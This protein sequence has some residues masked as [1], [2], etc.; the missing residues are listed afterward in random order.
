MT[1]EEL[2]HRINPS[3]SPD[4]RDEEWVHL[5]PTE[6]TDL[7]R[8]LQEAQERVAA[9]TAADKAYVDASL[10]RMSRHTKAAMRA[11]ETA[12]EVKFQA[13]V[14]LH[15]LIDPAYAQPAGEPK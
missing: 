11:E 14:A 3:G 10:H 15:E 5:S 12:S 2:R 9:W 7:A 8:Q 13:E 6:A 1:P 4:P